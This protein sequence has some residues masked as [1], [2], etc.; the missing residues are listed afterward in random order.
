M[1]E[2]LEERLSRFTPD[3]TCLNRDALLFSAGRASVRPSR[4]W[5][6]LTGALAASQVLTLLCL[7]ALMQFSPPP[8]T[9]I[10][11]TEPMLPSRE[12]IPA[13]KP[14][15]SEWRVLRQ[16]MQ[17]ADLEYSTPP[18]D[19][20]MAPQEPPLRAFGTPPPYLVN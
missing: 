4:R 12:S 6:A 10:I 3:A 18:S 5:Q 20:P 11:A 13:L 2:S 19:E 8:E 14:D 1:S 7:W 15:P 9:P 17:D 16:Q